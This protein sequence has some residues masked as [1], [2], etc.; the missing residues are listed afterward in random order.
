MNTNALATLYGT[1]AFNTLYGS[2]ATSTMLTGNSITGTS[3]LSPTVAARVQAAL[4]GQQGNIDALNASLSSTQTRLSGLGQL[5]SALDAFEA[6]AESLSGAGL[7]TSATSSNT[8]VLTAA[9]TPTAKPGTYTID[10]KQ[11]AQGQVLNSGVQPTA[12]SAIGAGLTATVKLEWGTLGADGFKATS[13]TSRTITI[14]SSNNTLEGIAGALEE[15]GVNATVVRSNGGYALQING[16]QGASQTLSI[17][18]SGDAALK[19][20][21]GFDPER[22]TAAGMTQAQAAQDAIISMGGKSTT[23]STNKL[24]ETIGGMTLTLTGKGTTK[25]T[26]S[27]DSSQIAKNVAAFVQGW[28]DMADK[29]AALEN[30]ALRGDNALSR[31][32]TQLSSLMRIGG[33]GTGTPSLADVGLS[34]DASGKLVLNEVK[35]KAAIADDPEAVTQLFTNEGRGLADRIDARLETMTSENGL[36]SRAQERTTRDLEVI[37]DRRERMAASLTA[38]AQALATMYTMQ[39]QMG[40]TGTLLDLLG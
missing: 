13:G 14:D 16:E 7:S 33:A 24:T 36:I 35:L 31:V 18:V 28:N 19:A 27:Q 39:E 10:V 22:P 40:G 3:T 8:A 12:T 4:A 5:Q 9:T 1:N 23:S 25:V 20:A 21:I 30:G 29:L 38:Q 34:R 17:S 15:A 32:T 26:V 2:N 37:T 11:L 6:M